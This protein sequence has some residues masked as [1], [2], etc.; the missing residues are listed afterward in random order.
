[1]GKMKGGIKIKG[2]NTKLSEMASVTKNSVVIKGG[3]KKVKGVK[4]PDLSG[5][6]WV[7]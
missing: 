7:K 1:M 3:D 4:G 6:G 5:G 2:P